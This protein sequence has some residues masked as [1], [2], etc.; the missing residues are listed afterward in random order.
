MKSRTLGIVLA[1]LVFIPTIALGD[2]GFIPA[3]VFEKVQIPDQ[4]ALIHFAAGDETLVIDTAFKGDGTNFAWIIPVPSVPVV[5]SATAGLFPTLQILFQPEIIH[6]VFGFY[7]LE[8][9][10][11]LIIAFVLWKRRRGES[12]VEILV[13][14]LVILALLAI[15]AGLLL[16]A[17][18][19]FTKGDYRPAIAQVDVIERKRVGVYEI[20]TLRS[21]DG[22]A[23]F[24]WLKQN[25]F[26]TR[27]NF[28]PAI[29]AYAKEGWC[30]VA[31]KIRL[32][33]PMQD[34]ANPHPLVV[35]FQTERPVYPLRLTGIDNGPCRIELYVFGPSRAELPN[36]RIEHCATLSYPTPDATLSYPTPHEAS[37]R[38]RVELRIRHP[39]LRSLVAG[40]PAATKLVGNLTSR[41]MQEDAYIAWTPLRETH[42]TRYSR[43][44]AATVAANIAVPILLVGLLGLLGSFCAAE[45]K[46]GWARSAIKIS[47]LIIIAALV[48]WGT[49]YVC[50][51]KTKVIVSS[52]PRLRM[53]ALHRGITAEL[54]IRMG[55]QGLRES[56]ET[57]PRARWVRQQ[58]AALDFRRQYFDYF[59]TNLF[60]GDLWHEE[61]SPG[62]Y[63]IR[64]T[65]VGIDYVW[66]DIEGGENVEPLFPK[67]QGK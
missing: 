39:F 37:G 35:K 49:T 36:F 40:S 18:G 22:Q 21:S 5:E 32:D 25:G 48:C 29:R 19:T 56:G 60:T 33:A 41:Q 1:W 11:G 61:D 52:R 4:R 13:E 43:Q 50:L 59:Q 34:A 57:T 42:V 15:F 45:T 55:K 47:G 7:W 24:D 63:T 31:S 44:G 17:L 20:A 67:P 30:F 28:I 12:L 16:P 66:Y 3:T 38:R 51:P 62:N 10:L 8:G 65:P 6:D 58:L 14:I 9:F 46:P 53:W 26:A 23:V 54:A 64:E 27:T 2:G